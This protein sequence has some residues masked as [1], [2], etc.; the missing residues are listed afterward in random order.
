M[1]SLAAR[2]R[3]SVQ[4]SRSLFEVTPQLFVDCAI[5]EAFLRK[6]YLDPG[7]SV[8]ARRSRLAEFAQ[9]SLFSA[10]NIRSTESLRPA[11]MPSKPTLDRWYLQARA[12]KTKSEVSADVTIM[13]HA[14]AQSNPAQCLPI[15]FAKRHD[16]R[17]KENQSV[18]EY[19]ASLNDMVLSASQLEVVQEAKAQNKRLTAEREKQS[20][21]DLSAAV[22]D[23]FIKGNQRDSQFASRLVEISSVVGS[24]SA[25]VEVVP[26]IVQAFL[27][28]P[29]ADK[30]TKAIVV[31]SSLYRY[32]AAE[33]L[34]Y[35]ESIAPTLR[36]LPLTYAQDA[37]K[38]H[39]DEF[40]VEF[41]LAWDPAMLGVR[42]V[43][44]GVSA[45][46]SNTGAVYAEQ[47]RETFEQW[48]LS[49]KQINIY[50]SDECAAIVGRV[51]SDP[52]TSSGALE[53]GKANGSILTIHAPC[54]C[55]GHD[56]CLKAALLAMSG[57][58]GEWY[59]TC[60]FELFR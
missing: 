28:K 27:H 35:V 2:K 55:H 12:Q 17:L 50:C 48:Q 26:L 32:R 49:E 5:K 46:P 34:G 47:R 24:V 4:Q 30:M 6:L 8:S 20:E 21:V 9:T 52:S 36:K 59:V 29:A 13:R 45:V 39:T 40:L 31:D 44:L 41:A 16:L 42:C 14:I 7:L 19:L 23:V 3:K 11:S 56:G 57:S 22:K 53:R 58:G 1:S 33:D 54:Q 37:S 38:L 51:S 43:L 60:S 25:T 18:L 10:L 15:S